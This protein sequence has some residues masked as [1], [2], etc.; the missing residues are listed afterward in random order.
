MEQKEKPFCW[1]LGAKKIGI[2]SGVDAS[3]P[4]VYKALIA[5]GYEP[6]RRQKSRHLKRYAK[7]ASNDQWNIDFVE[8]GVDTVT[9]KKIESLSVTDDHSRFTFS[10]DATTEATTEH[11]IDV[12]ERLFRFYGKP[13]VIHSDHGSQWYSTSSGVSRFDIWC[14]DNGIKHTMAPIRTPECNG[15]VER[16]HGCLRVEADLPAE[17]TVE[18]YRDILLRYRDFFNNHRP[19]CSLDY[20][21]PA[22]T[23]NKTYECERDRKEHDRLLA[24]YRGREHASET[25]VG[26][27]EARSIFRE[28]K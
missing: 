10:T 8:I 13:R 26:S 25:G 16:Y 28:L 5:A 21:T 18:D 3:A 1:N 7:P 27:A 24:I 4:T 15:K 22:E 9:G 19:N 14:Q 23:Y 11:V 20:R 2:L 12:L 17:G 6:I